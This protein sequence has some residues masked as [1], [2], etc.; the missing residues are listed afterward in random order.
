MAIFPDPVLLYW[1]KRGHG[2]QLSGSAQFGFVPE[3]DK[4]IDS[5]LDTK[6][7]FSCN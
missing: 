1:I 2:E 6:S 4:S 3:P 5:D 7:L